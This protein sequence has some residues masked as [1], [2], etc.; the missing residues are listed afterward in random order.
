M[1]AGA[2]AART[3]KAP[4]EM[5]GREATM[6][7]ADTTGVLDA[8]A[9]LTSSQNLLESDQKIIDVIR[10]NGDSAAQMTLADIARASK[11][12]EAT[13]SRFCR[14]LGFKGYREFQLSLACDLSGQEETG[15][16]DEVSLENMEQS[17]TNI[18]A[19]KVSEI[20]ATIRGIDTKELRKIVEAIS[21]AEIVE[22]A[23]VGNTIPV[24]MDAAFKFNQLGIRAVTSEVSEKLSALALTLREGDVLLLV[25]NSGKS[26]RLNR[27]ARAAKQGGALII[28]IT[29]AADSPLAR[30][31]DHK[32]VAVNHEGM[33]T[34]G[35]FIFSKISTIA[36]V[37]VIH[38]FLLAS[39]PSAC[40]NMAR[41]EELIAPDKR[42]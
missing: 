12:S 13:V 9:R 40:Q 27:V 17:L 32:L 42:V 15:V 37:E 8:L 11:T 33:L 24:A 1:L 7:T 31:S 36:L 34:T 18:L 21:R 30:L 38:H 20:T 28:L 4:G 41:H 39:L 35:D 29:G 23:A 16:T 26:R 6:A 22:I 25:S 19:T 5:T 2:M 10:A 14:R 3:R